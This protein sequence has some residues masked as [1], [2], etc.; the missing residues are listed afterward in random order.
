[1]TLL[2]LE[3]VAPQDER[4]TAALDGLVR[5]G[6]VMKTKDGYHLAR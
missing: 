4:L 5:D 1:M 3:A 2:E 6:L